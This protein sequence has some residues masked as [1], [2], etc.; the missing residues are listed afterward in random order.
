MR[1]LALIFFIFLGGALDS[2]SSLQTTG[3]SVAGLRSRLFMSTDTHF[4]YLVIGGGSG[5]VASAR[6]AAG[7]GAKVGIIEKNAFGG[8]CVNVGCVPK[9]VMWNAAS[10]NEALHNAGQFGFT[11]GDY[12]LD[13]A[14]LKTARDAYVT[15]LN[16]IYSRMM[17][18]NKIQ[19]FEG[20]G[21]FSGP[22]EVT[23]KDQKLT[24]TNILIA[25]GGRP[26][27][28]KIP[29]AE[30]GISSDGFFQLKAQ[31]KSVA[32][33]GGGYIGVE[34]AGV[35]QALGTRTS[36]FTQ[37]ATPLASF[38]SLVV[39]TLMSEMKKQGIEH[40]PNAYT[41]S[42][43]KNADGS[44]TVQ[45]TTGSHG[46]YECVLFATGRSPLTEG[47]GL[48]A[49]GVKTDKS[50]FIEVDDFQQTSTP[51]VFAVGDV[52]GK[53]QL[54]PTAIAAGRRLADR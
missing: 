40:V 24:A 11:V 4:D 51:G 52:C 14:R 43:V 49:A 42:I 26:A 37:S 20:A 13:W 22:N 35:F 23:V 16:G 31:P 19:V 48:S 32:V 50:G 7:Y 6:R 10:V 1:E 21:V 25:V 8:T 33:I 12:S 28:P 54:T 2:C 36:L 53:I 38:D 34:L 5:G 41:Q 29:G 47:L 18:N 27:V 45:T 44:L 39:S 30:Y 17:A 9:K 3:R 15:R 46:P